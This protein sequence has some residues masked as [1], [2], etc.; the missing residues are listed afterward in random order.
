MR[1]LIGLACLLLLVLAG[2][3][4]EDP[5][6]SD[7]APGTLVMVAPELIWDDGKTVIPLPDRHSVA[8]EGLDPR[9]QDWFT[10][11]DPDLNIPGYAITEGTKLMVL[12]DWQE[13]RDSTKRKWSRPRPHRL[14][15]VRPQDGLFAG[16]DC[17]IE[18]GD[19]IALQP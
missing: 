7:L 18:R 17:L 4:K 14:V 9:D 19:L 3:A 5:K 16:R 13:S 1:R 12:A 10:F 11:D 6:F 2:C 15:K 8:A